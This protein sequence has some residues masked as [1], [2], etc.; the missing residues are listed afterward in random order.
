MSL[1][2]EEMGIWQM[3]LPNRENIWMQKYC[4]G[5]IKK[6]QDAD[7][8]TGS[9]ICHTIETYI[10]Q[11]GDMKQTAEQIAVHEN[12]VR[13]RLKKAQE[14]LKLEDKDMEFQQTIWLAFTYKDGLDI[15]FDT[16]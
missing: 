6:L 3:I 4:K 10:K 13:Y 12:T 14:V 7:Q 1:T 15:Y 5:I 2:I 11:S 16:F 9:E 8:E